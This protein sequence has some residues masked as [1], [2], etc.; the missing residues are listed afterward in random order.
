[1][2]SMMILAWV[3]GLAVAASGAAPKHFDVAA[4]FTAP[5]RA[6]EAG[7]VNV[8]FSPTDPDVRINEEPAPRLKLAPAQGVLVDRQKP[9]P[10]SSGSEVDPEKSRYLDLKK[11]YRFP[12]A[13]LSEAPKGPQE[14]GATVVY[15][16]CSK[17]EGWCRRGNAE[18]KL[19]VDV[20]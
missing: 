8:L 7:T 17:R 11:P 12:V 14:V 10:R 19:T 5:A 16:Y 6:G 13:I 4:S 15:F 2:P 20:P 9:A 3:A 18:I 1:M